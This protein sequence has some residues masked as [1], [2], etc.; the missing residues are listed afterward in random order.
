MSDE[1]NNSAEKKEEKVET[2]NTENS[3]AENLI[4]KPGRKPNRRFEKKGGRGRSRS[5]KKKEAKEFEE[6]VLQIDR[7][8]RVVKG[9]RR[10]RFRVTVVIGDRKGRVGIGIGKALDVVGGIS[11]AVAD[12]KKNLISVPLRS[13]TIPHEIKLKFKA[14]NIM[15]MPG[16]AGSGIIAGGAV[17]KVCDL[18]GVENIT[19]KSFGTN[20]RIANAQAAITAFKKLRKA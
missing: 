1:K 13:G 5:G 14:A 10:L 11:K 7:V 17:R 19:A 6:E 18:A 3:A 4:K 2:K 20:N 15:L 8:T 12:G 16:R 9:G